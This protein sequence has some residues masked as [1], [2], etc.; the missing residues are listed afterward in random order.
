MKFL[1]VMTQVMTQMMKKMLYISDEND[2]DEAQESD[3]ENQ[4]LDQNDFK[5]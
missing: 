2:G 1:Q 3:H 4:V 5:E